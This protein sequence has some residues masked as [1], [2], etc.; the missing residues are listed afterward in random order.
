MVSPGA[1]EHV[2]LPHAALPARRRGEH[3]MGMATASK[4]WTI[5]MVRALPDDRNRYEI[6]DGDLFVTPAPSWTHQ[7]AVLQLA[8]RLAPYLEAER[9]GKAVIAP[10]DIEVASD[11]M[12]EPDLFVVP[13]VAGRSPRSW[14]EAGRLLLVV[15]VLSPSTARADRVRKRALYARERVP[16][17]WIVDVDARVIERWRP[18]DERPEIL[19][20][21]LEW[22][23]DP[24]RPP[25]TIDL[26]D[27]FA[28]LG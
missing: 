12:V 25:L 2:M 13:L 19:T 7:G 20:E 8:L 6:I 3:R 9:L 24:G 10:A 18:D 22:Q 4:H 23:P 27:Y 21:R 17:Y 1:G 16:Q 26:V 15:E 14:T 11:T 5:D 28:A